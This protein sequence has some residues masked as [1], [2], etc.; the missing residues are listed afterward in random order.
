MRPVGRY[1]REL[2]DNVNPTDWENPTPSGRYH[3]VAIG[4]GTAGLVSAAGAAGLGARAALIERNMLGGDCL[5]VGCVP[6][7][8]VI[9][10]ARAWTAARTARER[11]AGP[12]VEQDGDFGAAMERMRRLRAGISR[13]DSARRFRDLGVD[14]YLGHARFVGPDAIEVDGQRLRFRRAVVATGGRAAAPPIAGLDQ[15]DYL[16]NESIFSLTELPS[17]LGII[18]AGPIGCEMAQSFAR[19]GSQV[20]LLEIAPRILPREDGDAAEVVQGALARDGVDLQLGVQIVGVEARGDAVAVVL[21][22]HGS[23]EMIEVDQLLVAVGRSPNVEGLGLDTA[24][25]QYDRRGVLVD[26]RLRTSNKR[27]FACGAVASKYQFTHTADAQARIVTQNALF[28]PTAK[29]SKLVVPWCTYTSPEVAHVG[30]HAAE[31]EE[32]GHAVQS[33]TIPLEQVDRAVLDGEG[34]GF[35]RVHHDK[36]KILGATLVAAH[37]GEMI[38]ELVLAMTAGVTLGQISGTIHP[39]PTQGEVVRK[40]GDAF[41]RG[42]LTPTVTR[43]L[44]AWFRLTS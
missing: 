5:N 14:V 36:G 21:E 1:D 34:E 44:A 15:V 35:L 37:A 40:A 3:L 28:L 7:K 30:L 10:A 8:G 17:R 39:Y 32:R 11:F 25:I 29:A 33:I 42:G 27:V 2:L 9:S 23:G 38:G 13:H 16:T 18:G 20:T 26:D 31:A 24:G 12:G 43:A 6:S 4:G 41:R 19:F 22:G